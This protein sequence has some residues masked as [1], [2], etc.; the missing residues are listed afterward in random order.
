MN[1]QDAPVQEEPT[2]E[3]QPAPEG[4]AAPV[5]EPEAPVPD[6]GTEAP[7]EEPVPEEVV[8]PVVEQL[9]MLS[10]L[11]FE[12]YFRSELAGLGRAAFRVIAEMTDAGDVNV[13][14]YREGVSGQ[15]FTFDVIGELV[16]NTTQVPV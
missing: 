11:N 4:E 8:A 2:A 14:V 13:Q 10:P 3:A 7:A 9:T 15:I 12:Q 5:A 16:R 1:D 6:E